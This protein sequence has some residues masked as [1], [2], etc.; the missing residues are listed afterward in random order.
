MTSKLPLLPISPLLLPQ[1]MLRSG[2]RREL[3]DH[4][5]PPN[6]A[7]TRG[8][9]SNAPK[10]Q[11]A[12]LGIPRNRFSLPSH[13]VVLQ[14]QRLRH[15]RHR[16]HR[17]PARDNPCDD[18]SRLV[19]SRRQSSCLGFRN[20]AFIHPSIHPS[21]ACKA[22]M[23]SPLAFGDDTSCS[24]ERDGDREGEFEGL[25]R[26]PAPYTHKLWTKVCGKRKSRKEPVIVLVTGG[27][28]PCALY[29]RLIEMLGRRWRVV[30]WDR[31]GYDRSEVP[32]VG[33]GD[34]DGDENGA[35][36]GVGKED[37]D[38]DGVSVG[39]RGVGKVMLGWEMGRGD[40]HGVDGLRR[41]KGKGKRERKL[42]AR[43]SAEEFKALLNV[44]GVKGP[45]V[46]LAYSYGGIVA[47]AIIDLFN[48]PDF[49]T[50][51]LQDLSL[52]DLAL[53]ERWDDCDT[54]LPNIPP[55]SSNKVVGLSMIEPATELLYHTFQPSIPPP[56]FSA[57]LAGIDEEAILHLRR[58]SKL[59]D[60]E[61]DALVEAVE[62]TIPNAKYE[63]PRASARVLVE[64]HQFTR[65]VLDPWPVAV[66]RCDF[67]WTWEKLF[68][69]GVKRGNGSEEERRVCREF[70]WGMGVWLDEI[71]AGVV[72]LTGEDGDMEYGEGEREQ[73]KRGV[74]RKFTGQK[75][76]Y[77]YF[78]EC[79]H[80]VPI[81]RP[82]EV[83]KEVEWVMERLR[84]RGLG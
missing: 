17:I 9:L 34:G 33:E 77:R 76:R 81:V 72:R 71:W 7:N 14:A 26:L 75:R 55:Q 66:L 2:S 24:D 4:N 46:L 3:S 61:W 59:T 47:R 74:D 27:A 83:V 28:A 58:D 8:L 82:E 49:D 78:G 50:S 18:N 65:H 84:E 41:A 29:V 25:V 80:E 13:L 23:S 19:M 22:T 45:Y 52:Q 56:A 32:W 43:D 15:D 6:A 51:S 63:D 48:G 69:A 36:E 40:D 57:M 62:R 11:S 68:D 35:E 38:G 53:E 5:L 42:M 16:W 54:P 60:P 70:L 12:L 79:G 31:A 44:I 64:Q 37:G 67:R 30:A 39:D 1:T 21:I 20:R 10:F 73:E